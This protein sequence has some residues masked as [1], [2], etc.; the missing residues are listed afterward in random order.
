MF[1]FIGLVVWMKTF[2]TKD[3]P[4]IYS[5]PDQMPIYNWIYEGLADLTY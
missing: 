5:E 4:G 2:I 3:A 1:V